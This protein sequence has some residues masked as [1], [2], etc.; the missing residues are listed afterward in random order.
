ME[1]DV[2]ELIKEYAAVEAVAEDILSDKQQVKE[3]FSKGTVF[4]ANYLCL[5]PC[6]L[7]IWTA[8]GTKE[9]KHYDS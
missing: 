9:G 5:P 7:W 6:R 2:D 4:F 1:Q 3:V 8:D